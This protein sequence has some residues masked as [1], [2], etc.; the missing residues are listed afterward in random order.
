MHPY[1]GKSLD[2]R[3]RRIPLGEPSRSETFF[4][5]SL[6]G[7]SA[8]IGKGLRADFLKE[9]G[10]LTTYS[11][12]PTLA[13]DGFGL[14]PSAGKGK[15]RADADDQGGKTAGWRRIG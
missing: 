7:I 5:S 11:R 3:K 6:V 8:R 15:A 12:N 13:A 1:S 10:G 9:E 14:C 4:L 2:G